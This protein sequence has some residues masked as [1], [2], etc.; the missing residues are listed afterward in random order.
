MQMTAQQWC[1]FLGGKLEGN[2]NVLI[3]HP[4]KIEEADEGAI[5]FIAH[6]KYFSF[7]YN[8]KASA[9]IVGDHSEFDGKVS[10]TL[11]RVEQPYVAFSLVLE[12]FNK[13]YEGLKGA[14]ESAVVDPSAKIGE[15]VFI[16]ALSC[17]GKNVMLGKNVKIF[18]EVFIGDD[19]TIAEDTIIY[20][21]VHIYRECVLGER[22]TI[23]SGTV[24]GSDGFGFAP[25][26]DGAYMKIPQLGNVVIESDVEIGANCTIDRATLGSTLIHQGVKLDNLIH[27]AHNVEIGEHTVIAA[28][29]GV[30]GSTKIGKHC[31]IGGQ[32]G[33]VGHLT[34][35][36]GTKINAQS[37]VSKS[38][39][40]KNKAVTGSP[41]FDYN[42]SLR[43]QAVFRNLP[44]LLK[45]L[46]DLEQRVKEF[47]MINQTISISKE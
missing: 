26:P 2:G 17:V 21:G 46:D 34:I 32:V 35:A 31:Q 12:K 4:A 5:S 28:Q 42:S 30:S 13:P 14:H 3:S 38:I 11:I 33:L 41:A 39:T 1:D 7:A 19:V 15:N 25:Q 45:R 6:P 43:S 29:T 23:H 10:A 47:E 36:D 16:G 44:E 24:I 20:S 37:G 27:I 8:T 40:Q 18:P 9:L 22:C